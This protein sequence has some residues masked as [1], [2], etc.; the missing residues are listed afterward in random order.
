MARQNN[1]CDGLPFKVSFDFYYIKKRTY[2]PTNNGKT[3][4]TVQRHSLER[5]S[6]ECARKVV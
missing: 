2:Y 5:K 3:V 1:L 6:Y 4:L